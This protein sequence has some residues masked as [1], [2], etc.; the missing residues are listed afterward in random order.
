MKKIDKSNTVPKSLNNKTTNKRRDEIIKVG[1]YPTAKN[2]S[3]FPAKNVG[4]YD[5]RYKQNDIK[6]ALNKLYKGK[7]VYCETKNRQLAVEHYRP[8][9][10]YY[11]LVYSW[12]N[13]LYSCPI[14]NSRK[15]DK[16]PIKNTKHQHNETDINQ[17]HKLAPKYNEYEH[18]ELINPETDDIFDDI[19]YKR[20][21]EFDIEKITNSRL[22]E[23]IKLLKLNDVEDLSINRKAVYDKLEQAISEKIYEIKRGF[24]VE[25]NKMRIEQIIEIFIKDIDNEF[26]TFRK[27]IIKNWIKTMIN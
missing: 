21:G 12:D 8:K 20:N 9:S 7:C 17:I 16:F 23:T 24:E 19:T 15:S 25:K 18:P 26:Y 10:E 14:C 22:L 11:W 1:E 5:S 3:Q 6:T 27:Y 2:I 13:L 4:T